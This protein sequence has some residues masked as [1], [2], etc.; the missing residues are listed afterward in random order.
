MAAALVSKPRPWTN[1]AADSG[2]PPVAPAG[3]FIA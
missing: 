3:A 2:V 1:A